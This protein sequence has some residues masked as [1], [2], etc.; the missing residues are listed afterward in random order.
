MET[1]TEED[2]KQLK[3]NLGLKSACEAACVT[4]AQ[5]AS[6]WSRKCPRTEGWTSQVEV[7]AIKEVLSGIASM[8]PSTQPDPAERPASFPSW[9]AAW[10]VWWRQET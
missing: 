4:L 7:D 9:G 5:S 3:S 1:N 6:Y 2:Q 10:D 8:Y